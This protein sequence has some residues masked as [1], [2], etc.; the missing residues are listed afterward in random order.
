MISSGKNIATCCARATARM[1]RHSA[2]SREFA[3]KDVGGFDA[4]FKSPR[5]VNALFLG[6][7][8]RGVLFARDRESRL[9]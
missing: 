2:K 7:P 3:Q 9:G 5:A 4:K 8:S 6:S 1:D